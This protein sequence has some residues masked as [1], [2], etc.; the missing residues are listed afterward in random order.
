VS[1]RKQRR[2]YFS[3]HV[4]KEKTPAGYLKALLESPYVE[5][6]EQAKMLV[7]HY[8]QGYFEEGDDIEDT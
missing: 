5:H 4:K 6:R 1:N 2:R 8:G 7:Q 3:L